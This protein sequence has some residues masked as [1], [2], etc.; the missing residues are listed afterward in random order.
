M[1]RTSANTEKRDDNIRVRE[2]LYTTTFQDNST[3]N[4]YS[5]YPNPMSLEVQ[6][7]NRTVISENLD[8]NEMLIVTGTPGLSQIPSEPTP[9]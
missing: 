4:G 3:G 1:I 5:P 8:M 6:L 9:Q 2:I 7:S